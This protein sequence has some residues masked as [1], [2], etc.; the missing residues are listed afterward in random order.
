MNKPKESKAKETEQKL[1]IKKTEV[2]KRLI[3]LSNYIG[4]LR[5]RRN[6]K[7]DKA[8]RGR[9]NAD[10]KELNLLKQRILIKLIKDNC[11][12]VSQTQV[13]EKACFYVVK[14]YKDITFHLPVSENLLKI[15]R[16]K[17]GYKK[18]R[19]QFAPPGQKK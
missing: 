11:A 9:L 2:A 19:P 6:E 4:L 12:S 16:K 17:H 18:I 10:I 8:L 13:S 7:T 3:Y 15:M 14:L 1:L 5:Q